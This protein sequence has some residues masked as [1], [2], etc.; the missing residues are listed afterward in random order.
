MRRA[1][2]TSAAFGNEG[3]SDQ[4]RPEDSAS[5]LPLSNF[6]MPAM[7]WTGKSEGKIKPKPHGTGAQASGIGMIH[8]E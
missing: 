7:N 3:G 1:A 2:S 6:A 4:V 8:T 5:C